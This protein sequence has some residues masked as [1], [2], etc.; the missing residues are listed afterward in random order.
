M[1]LAKPGTLVM[2]NWEVLGCNRWIGLVTGMVC[3]GAGGGLLK[4]RLSQEKRRWEERR[5]GKGETR[6]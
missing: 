4:T 1:S 5:G 2:F 6:G 3:S